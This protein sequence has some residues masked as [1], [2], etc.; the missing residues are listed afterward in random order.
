MPD[1][2]FEMPPESRRKL[3][4]SGNYRWMGLTGLGLVGMSLIFPVVAEESWPTEE[5][6]FMDLPVALTA[7]R[8][9][10]PL[11]EAPA[12]VT[13]IDRD[14]IQNSQARDIHELL[15][16]V[17]G[18]VVGS[19]SGGRPIVTYHG[20]AEQFVRQ[21]QVLV[22]GRSLYTSINGGVQWGALDL[23]PDDIERIEVIRGPNAAAYGSNSFFAIINILTRHSAET[24]GHQ[25]STRLG[26]NGVR[27]LRWRYGGSTEQSSYR[28]AIQHKEDD[29]FP[30][31]YDQRHIDTFSAR[32]DW[33]PQP[34]IGI[35]TQLGLGQTRKGTDRVRNRLPSREFT[36]DL[37]HFHLQVQNTRDPD[38]THRLQYYFQFH[39]L[40]DGFTALNNNGQPYRT[41]RNSRAQRHD[42]ELESS[43][44]ISPDS[45]IV[46]GGSARLD[47]SASSYYFHGRGWIDNDLYRAFGHMEWSPTSQWLINLGGMYEYNDITGDN[48]MP[49]GAVIYMPHPEHSLRFVASRAVRTPSLAEEEIRMVDLTADGQPTDR[50][51]SRGGLKPEVIHSLELGYHLQFAEGQLKADV[52][53]FQ[54]ELRDLIQMPYGLFYGL[55]NE[56]EFRNVGGLTLQGIETQWNYRPTHRLRLL[57]GFA[58][59]DT[60]QVA[61][62]ARPQADSIPGHTFNLGLMFKPDNAWTL[63]MEYYHYGSIDWLDDPGAPPTDAGDGFLDLN[64]SRTL[65]SHASATLSVKDALASGFDSRL[66]GPV[67]RGNHRT[68]EAYLSLSLNF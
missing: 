38:T 32:S 44:R 15:R 57:A 41:N 10:Q 33:N 48:L 6:F 45:R 49:R 2:P 13:V 25:V 9:E 42:L 21:L 56:G 17:P 64:L 14:W 1:T 63:T 52:K 30:D 68:T 23:T 35:T 36:R 67:L 65:G 5:D 27:D 47:R 24:Q 62:E 8:L 61:T 7:T 16:M 12:S 55:E 11:I 58:L 3:L 31:K 60:T 40:Q 29:G 4:S 54:N 37:G 19:T 28:V 51:V 50:T 20:F 34:G 22:D 53:L 26:S 59:L 39:D 18:F 46:Y 43:H 66:D